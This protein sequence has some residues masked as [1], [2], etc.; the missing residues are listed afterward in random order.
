MTRQRGKLVSSP[1]APL[2]IATVHPSSILRAP[3][4]DAR[5]SQM[6]AFVNDLKIVADLLRTAKVA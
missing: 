2:V 6:N 4:E 1:L 5:H 3:D